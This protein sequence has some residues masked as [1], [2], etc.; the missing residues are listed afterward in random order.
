M[1]NSFRGKP[2]FFSI[3]RSSRYLWAAARTLKHGRLC[4]SKKTR[5]FE[6]QPQKTQLHDASHGF[7]SQASAVTSDVRACACLYPVCVCLCLCVCVS[8]F[9]CVLRGFLS[10]SSVKVFSACLP[11]PPF[12][13]SSIHVFPHILLLSPLPLRARARRTPVDIPSTCVCLCTTQGVGS[14]RHTLNRRPHAAR[15]SGGDGGVLRCYFNTIY[16]CIYRKTDA[17]Q[18]YLFPFKVMRRGSRGQGLTR[19]ILVAKQYKQGLYLFELVTRV[20]LI[21]LMVRWLANN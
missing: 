7:Q 17:P 19:Q 21:Y 16:V 3:L 20:F 1:I 10:H 15:H 12:A 4:F 13:P 9:L 18:L 6:K 8:V 2:N 5:T 11:P 14:P